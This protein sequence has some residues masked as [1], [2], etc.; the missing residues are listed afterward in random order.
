MLILSRYHTVIVS[1]Y[2]F[3]NQQRKQTVDETEHILEANN[4]DFKG[5]IDEIATGTSGSTTVK[6][7][8]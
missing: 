3:P 6:A 7:Y 8:S 1:K 2:E 4:D 5:V